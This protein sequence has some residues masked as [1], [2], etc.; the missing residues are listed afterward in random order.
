MKSYS[1]FFVIFFVVL[2]FSLSGAEEL[3][4]KQKE[5]E[6]LRVFKI[7]A[8][9][10]EMLNQMPK[11]SG[12]LVQQFNQLSPKEQKYL[13]SWWEQGVLAIDRYWGMYSVPVFGDRLKIHPVRP[14]RHPAVHLVT[15]QVQEFGTLEV[16]P[17]KSIPDGSAV[18]GLERRGNLE[19][20]NFVF[21]RIANAVVRSVGNFHFTFL[22][23]VVP[24]LF[25]LT[26]E[27]MIFSLPSHNFFEFVI[28]AFPFELALIFLK[29]S[30]SVF[31]FRSDSENGA[32]SL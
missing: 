1:F 11:N 8:E 15:E 26:P 16:H 18:C 6:L 29:L 10:N 25:L 12:E 17:F 4:A 14:R 30:T 28:L 24:F 7:S 2:T 31:S 20:W 27:S 3:S 5:E 32:K 9:R 21:I 22:S 23:S 13:I 19:R